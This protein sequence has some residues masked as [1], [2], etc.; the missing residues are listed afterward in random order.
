MISAAVNQ[1]KQRLWRGLWINTT[2]DSALTPLSA[3]SSS[4]PKLEY[5]ESFPFSKAVCCSVHLKCWFAGQHRTREREQVRRWNWHPDLPELMEP[6]TT[7]GLALSLSLSLYLYI[8]NTYLYLYLP[9][10]TCIYMYEYMLFY[11]ILHESYKDYL[12]TYLLCVRSRT[13]Q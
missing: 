7:E 4:R 12:Y 3:E 1:E 13:E 10:Y 8:P 11:I 5:L 9:I 6:I 2:A